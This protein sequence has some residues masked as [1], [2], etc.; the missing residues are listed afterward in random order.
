[1][2]VTLK[3]TSGNFNIVKADEMVDRLGAD[4]TTL[5]NKKAKEYG[6]DGGVVVKKINKGVIDDQTRMRDGFIITK[7]NGKAVKSVEELKG[8]IGSLKDVKVEGI[9]PGY[10][11]IFEYPLSLDESSSG[12]EE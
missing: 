10:N 8:V 12:E 1:M 4:L 9:Y 2:S 6:I 7:V 5:D 11:E 3:N